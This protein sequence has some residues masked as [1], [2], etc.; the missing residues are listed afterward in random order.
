M[1]KVA[2]LNSCKNI[3]ELNFLFLAHAY[4]SKDYVRTRPVPNGSGPK[5]RT[6]LDVLFTTAF[7]SIRSQFGRNFATINV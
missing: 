3:H 5:S 4:N 7:A 2:Q 1:L 6:G